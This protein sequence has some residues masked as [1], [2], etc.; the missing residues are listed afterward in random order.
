MARGW[1]RWISSPRKRSSSNV[2]R[3][4]GAVSFNENH[5]AGPR[6]TV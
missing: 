4:N 6:I 3:R 1:T 5:S 2:G